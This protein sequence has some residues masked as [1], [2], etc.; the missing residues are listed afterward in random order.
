M[1]PKPVSR[2]APTPSGLLHLGNA[3]NFL[4]TWLLV[5]RENGG[6]HLRIDDLDGFRARREFVE[7]IFF[8]L[9]WLGLD[10]DE[11]PTGPDDFYARFSQMERMDLYKKPLSKL[12]QEGAAYACSC[13][14]KDIAVSGKKGLYP[15]TCRKKGLLPE[16]GLTS[17]RLLVPSGTQVH[18]GEKNFLL[19]EK[20]GDFVLWRKENLAAYHLVSVLEDEAMGINLV[21]RGEDLFP[22]TCAQLFLAQK[23]KLKHFPAALFIHHALVGH[24]SGEKL[25]KSK[26]SLSLSEMRKGGAGP[27]DIFRFVAKFLCMEDKTIFSLNDLRL[28]FNESGKFSQGNAD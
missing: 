19:D 6:L 16:A 12:L 22:S 28:L 27:S 9:D 7:D 18:P 13:S 23:L 11:G 26:H 3:V 10:W 5:R 21:V 14:R 15:G 8:C 20:F 17:I 1:A 4:L 2:L 24:A 25:S